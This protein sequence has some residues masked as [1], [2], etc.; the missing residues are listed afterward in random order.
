MKLFE[1]LCVLSQMCSCVYMCVLL[2]VLKE[3]C[4]RDVNKTGPHSENDCFIAPPLV[5]KPL[6]VTFKF[7]VQ[8]LHSAVV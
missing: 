4:I 5:K 2:Y 6:R 8:N 7:K 1:G 3:T